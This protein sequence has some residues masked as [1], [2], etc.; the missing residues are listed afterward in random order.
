LNPFELRVFQEVSEALNKI[1]ENAIADIYVVSLQVF[2][3][4]EDPRRPMAQ[5]G[6]NTLERVRDSTSVG[7][8]GPTVDEAKWNFAFYLQNALMFVGEPET[9]AGGLLEALLKAEGLWYSDE[10]I[11]HDEERTY[12]RD[13]LITARFV[14]MLLR[15]VQEL[16][17]SGLIAQ[18]FGRPI[19]VLV[20]ELEYYDEIARQNTLANPDG[21]ADEFAGWIDRGISGMNS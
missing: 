14:A 21:L 13:P 1:P 15:V 11:E 8:E 10:D 12:E 5:L 6:Y 16:H 9:L 17:A 19:P 18:R 2:D 20:H 4:D 7:S 3:L